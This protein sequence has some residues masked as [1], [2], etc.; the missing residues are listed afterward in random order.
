[1]DKTWKFFDLLIVVA[2]VVMGFG[3]WFLPNWAGSPEMKQLEQ[4][5]D[6]R[7]EIKVHNKAELARRAEARAA[8]E[9]RLAAEREEQGLIFIAPPPRG[10]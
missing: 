5:A 7:H 4:I 1:M 3:I 9:K 6:K 2:A 10:N 8:E